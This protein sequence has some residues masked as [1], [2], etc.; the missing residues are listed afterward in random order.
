VGGRL[1][2][3]LAPIHVLAEVD[4]HR[5]LLLYAGLQAGT[6]LPSAGQMR[7]TLLLPLL[8]APQNLNG[9]LRIA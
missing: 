7:N 6:V 1:T 4:L 5:Q 2:S 9:G 3:Q 8:A